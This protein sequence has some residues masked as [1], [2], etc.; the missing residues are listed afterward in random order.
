M[1]SKLLQPLKAKVAGKRGNKH[2]LA[3]LSIDDE[4]GQVRIGFRC[5]K[6]WCGCSGHY[7]LE[8]LLEAVE[9]FKRENTRQGE[10]DKEAA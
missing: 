3:P 8:E 9:Q 2:T 1:L 7:S 5:P 10:K 6:L 4:S